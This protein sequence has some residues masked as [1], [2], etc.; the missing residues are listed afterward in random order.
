MAELNAVDYKVTLSTKASMPVIPDIVV[1]GGLAMA[2]MSFV[3]N[4]SV[5]PALLSELP[6]GARKQVMSWQLFFIAA[7]TLIVLAVPAAV[8]ASDLPSDA[9]ALILAYDGIVAA[10]AAAYTFSTHDKRKDR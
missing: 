9:Q 5:T 2:P 3:G 1:S 10:Y 6:A 7:I 4:G 8:L